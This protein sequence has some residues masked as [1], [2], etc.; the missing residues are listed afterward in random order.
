VSEIQI[1]ERQTAERAKHPTL[2]K[3]RRRPKADETPLCPIPHLLVEPEP[4]IRELPPSA[5]A[6]DPEYLWGDW[7][8]PPRRRDNRTSEARIGHDTGHKLIVTIDLD[9]AGEPCALA[10]T[11]HKEGAVFRGMLDTI[12]TLASQALQHGASIQEVAARMRLVR[13]EPDGVVTEHPTIRSCTSI[14]DLLGQMLLAE[15]PAGDGHITAEAEKARG[16]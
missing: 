9:D 1:G 3:G 6:D 7:K 12:A 4:P 16:T 13:F 14:V 11:V 2:G 10:A 15:F 8:A 5:A